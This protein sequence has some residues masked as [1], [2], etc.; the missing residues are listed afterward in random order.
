MSD[1]KRDK[2]QGPRIRDRKTLQMEIQELVL[3][4]ALWRRRR[5]LL[6]LC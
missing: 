5:E 1:R 4:G 3:S 2:E 6:Y